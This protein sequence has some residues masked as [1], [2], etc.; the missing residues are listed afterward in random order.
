MI[1]TEVCIKLH[2]I[3]L[4]KPL[5]QPAVVPLLVVAGVASTTTTVSVPEKIHRR[6]RL[7]QVYATPS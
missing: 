2:T 7:Q 1:W 6:A 5:M 4:V 3:V